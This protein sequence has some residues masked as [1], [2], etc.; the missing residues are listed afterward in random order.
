MRWAVPPPGITPR[1]VKSQGKDG[2]GGLVAK[3]GVQGG[4]AVERVIGGAGGYAVG[5]GH[6]FRSPEGIRGIV[7]QQRQPLAYG[8][9]LAVW[10]VIVADGLAVGV[11]QAGPFTS[12]SVG[13]ADRAGIRCLNLCDTAQ[14]VRCEGGGAGGIG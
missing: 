13:I 9:E 14:G 5:A 7:C 3:V 2:E 4:R 10:G 8:V 11:G 1:P 12:C 6:G